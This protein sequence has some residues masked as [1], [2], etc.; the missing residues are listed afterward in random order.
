MAKRSGG[1][2]FEV[3]PIRDTAVVFA[4]RHLVRVL[5]KVAPADPVM[6]ADLRPAQPGEIRLGL[7]DARPIVSC[8]FL[9]V[10]D[11]PRVIGRVQPFPGV[12][13]VGVYHMPR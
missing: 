11:P 3:D 2:E 9:T 5:V 4:P 8:V 13:L 1:Y 10:V 7:I 12:R 6:L